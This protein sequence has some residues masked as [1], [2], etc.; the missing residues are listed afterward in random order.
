[1]SI[2]QA[3][4]PFEL[5]IPATSEGIRRALAETIQ[6]DYTPWIL[7]LTLEGGRNPIYP[8]R[9]IVPSN[10]YHNPTGRTS[11]EETTDDYKIFPS[12]QGVD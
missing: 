6:G 10:V 1:M 2:S 5:D 3:G 12:H 7:V 9:T 11:H 4:L 8:H